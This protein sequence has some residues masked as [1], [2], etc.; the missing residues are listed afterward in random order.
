VAMAMCVPAEQLPACERDCLWSPHLG[1]SRSGRRAPSQALRTVRVGGAPALG[2]HT[3]L[4][5]S[6][7]STPRRRP[8]GL[9]AWRPGRD[10]EGRGSRGVAG[11]LWYPGFAW[12]VWANPRKQQVR[13]CRLHVLGETVRQ[14]VDCS[15]RGLEPLTSSQRRLRKAL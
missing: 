1:A 8:S 13:I 3:A 14:D 5:T 11:M 15:G 2:R 4:S 9:V 10:C 7:Q 12:R 6:G